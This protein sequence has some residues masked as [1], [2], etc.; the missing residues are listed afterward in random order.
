MDNNSNHKLPFPDGD[1][2]DKHLDIFGLELPYAL[3]RRR[4]E[5]DHDPNCRNKFKSPLPDPNC[6]LCKLCHK[7]IL[8]RRR[9]R[10]NGSSRGEARIA[11]ALALKL[12]VRYRLPEVLLE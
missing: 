4:R 5:P 3:S 11:R 10:E 2:P 6:R 12:Q 9:N 7:I 1:C 8:I